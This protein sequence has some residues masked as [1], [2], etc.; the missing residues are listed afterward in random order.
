M[1]ILP[2]RPSGFRRPVPAAIK[3]PQE[4]SARRGAAQREYKYEWLA[5]RSLWRF[6][7]VLAATAAWLLVAGCIIEPRASTNDA[8]VS[9]DSCSSPAS[10]MADVIQRYQARQ[11][12]QQLRRQAGSNGRQ[13][14][15]AERPIECM[16]LEAA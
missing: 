11:T 5:G 2:G 16:Q 3:R 4:V 7:C 9:A 15:V 1:R 6:G 8:A 10:V 12:R 14:A 13:A